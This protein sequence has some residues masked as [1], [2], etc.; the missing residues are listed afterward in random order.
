MI[1]SIKRQFERFRRFEIAHLTRLSTQ[2]ATIREIDGLRFFAFALVFLLHLSNYVI[3]KIYHVPAGDEA[4]RTAIITTSRLAY[5]FSKGAF[6]VDVFFVI[7]GFILVIPFARAFK[8]EK[9][10]VALTGYY[11]RR[12]TRLEPPYIINLTLVFLMTVLRVGRVRE[13]L[14]HFVAAL[15]YVNNAIYHEYNRINPVQ[16]SLE[17]EVQFYI[18]APILSLPFRIRNYQQRTILLLSLMLSAG[19][20]SQ[21]V[22]PAA[23][24]GIPTEKTLLGHLH[25]FL[26]GFVFAN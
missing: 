6:G 18:L 13:L 21:F 9:P 7:S 1:T 10:P 3:G 4:A 12:L 23:I 26:V 8:G 24:C 15:F 5:A 17:I 25:Y 19:A 22:L 2:G 20:L 16:W 14:P 11:L